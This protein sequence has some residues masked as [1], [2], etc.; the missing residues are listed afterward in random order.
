MKWKR[1]KTRGP[2]IK[3]RPTA[4]IN[5]KHLDMFI[6]PSQIQLYFHPYHG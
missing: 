3:A 4:N 1:W 6:L 2:G 5:S